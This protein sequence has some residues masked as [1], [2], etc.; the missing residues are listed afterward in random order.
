MT[1]LFTDSFSQ[2]TFRSLTP[3]RQNWYD[4]LL[5]R[6]LYWSLLSTSFFTFVLH[7]FLWA[8]L[9]IK[10]THTNFPK[11]ITNALWLS[12]HGASHF[13]HLMRNW[14]GYLLRSTN[15]RWLIFPNRFPSELVHPS[16]HIVNFLSLPEFAT[17]CEIFEEYDTFC[18]TA[19]A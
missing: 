8:L 19:Q 12:I 17:T 6:K 5:T 10:N 13:D 4:W 7:Y 11:N 18:D 2:V 9:C 3:Q 1:D 16:I 15:F 14:P